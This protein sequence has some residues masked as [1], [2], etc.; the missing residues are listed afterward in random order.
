MKTVGE[1]WGVLEKTRSI[2]V[3][4]SVERN[5]RIEI[6]KN[7]LNLKLQ[8]IEGKR[9]IMG[10]DIGFFDHQTMVYTFE[11]I[12]IQQSYQFKTEKREPVI[13]DIGGNIGLATLFFKRLYPKSKITAFEPDKQTFKMLQA[14][15]QKNFKGVNLI[16]AAL[17]ARKGN[18]DFYSFEQKGQ[19][20]MSSKSPEHFTRIN[21]VKQLPLSDYLNQPIDFLKMDIE[22]SETEAICSA[23]SKLRN[24]KEMVLEFH[25]FPKVKENNL[26][27]LLKALER[28]KFH[29]TIYNNSSNMNAEPGLWNGLIN[30]KRKE[31]EKND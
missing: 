21:K 20:N 9:K 10:F 1:I 11:E 24:V 18:I 27:K 12:F 13:L 7:Y 5:E 26:P 2:L 4:K 25:A 31:A 8:K 28:N 19:A 14:N 16:N 30:A 22:G 29:F 23:K 17:G 15:I 3:N 6:A